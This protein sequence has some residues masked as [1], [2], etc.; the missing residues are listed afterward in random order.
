[1]HPLEGAYTYE[2]PKDRRGSHDL[3]R[4]LGPSDGVA[5]GWMAAGTG[6]DGPTPLPQQGSPPPSP[7]SPRGAS[8]APLAFSCL[9][10]PPPPR[11]T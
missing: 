11:P 1:M 3:T 4:R 5:A 7:R 2:S 8:R 9:C 10:F 6:P